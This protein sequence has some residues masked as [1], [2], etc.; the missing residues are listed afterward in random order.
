MPP[1]EQEAICA[2]Q[3]LGR[4]LRLLGDAWTLMII[5]TLLTGARRF[6]GLLE[7]LG[8]VSPKTLSHRLKML[9][10]LGFVQRHAFLEI[11]P[12]VEYCLTEKGLALADIMKAIEQFGEHYLSDAHPAS[13]DASAALPACE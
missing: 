6:G 4:A 5:H 10:E 9:E 8:N 3:P 11:P 7:A 2:T 1:T 12:R 13:S